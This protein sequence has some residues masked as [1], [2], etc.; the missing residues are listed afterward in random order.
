MKL[1]T[2]KKIGFDSNMVLDGV[3]AKISADDMHKLW[4]ILQDPY[5]NSIGAVVR[6]YVSNS[7]D[8]HA[9]AKFIKENSLTDIRTEYLIYND[10]SDEELL[11]LKKQLEVFDDDAVVV[12]I[13]DDEGGKYWATEDFGV[14]LS[15]SRVVD[16]FA[17]YLKST[18]EN[19]NNVIGAFGIGS[20]S[21]LSYS[22]I[23]FIRTRYNGYEYEYWLRKGEKGPRLD[24]VSKEPTTERNGTRIKIYIKEV[25]GEYHWQQPYIEHNRFSDECIKQLAYFDNVFFNGMTINNH[26]KIYQGNNWLYNDSVKN[27]SGQLHI[28]L[29]KVAYPLDFNTLGIPVI[30]VPLALKFEIGE[31]DIIQTREDIK[32]TPRSKKA[33]LDKIE[34][35]REEFTTKWETENTLETEDFILFLDNLGVNPTM[36][37]GNLA[38]DLT[39]L[40]DKKKLPSYKFAPFEKIGFTVRDTLAGFAFFD[41][42]IE[43]RMTPQRLVPD[44]IG[45]TEG[46]FLK[47]IRGYSCYRISGN[48]D[49]KKNKYIVNYLENGNSCFLVRKKGKYS[50]TLKNYIKYLRLDEFPKSEWRTIISTYQKA[51]QKALIDNT[52]SYDKT[53]VDKDWLASLKKSRTS[54][55]RTQINAEVQ[56]IVNNYYGAYSYGVNKEK[57]RK[58]L[59]ANSK[60]QYVIAPQ[61][62]RETL[63]I[64][65][66]LYKNSFMFRG[67]LS[68][69]VTFATVAPTNVK[70]FEGMDNVKTLDDFLK[71]NTLVFK[72]NM[73]V[74]LILDK[75]TVFNKNNHN[76]AAW[77]KI[78]PKLHKELHGLIQIADNFRALER[79]RENPIIKSMIKMAAENN[80]YDQDIIE[81]AETIEKVFKNLNLLEYFRHAN[82][83]DLAEYIYLAMRAGKVK[84]KMNPHL[85]INLNAKYNGLS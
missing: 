73:A 35:L 52:K 7:F 25:P 43:Y 2:S 69:I 51:A 60:K 4:D 33:I 41:Y 49:S 18:K 40:I 13:Y 50:I 3:D 47:L 84:V 45:G 81:K 24:F 59:I 58:D 29:G 76:T 68:N 78:S 48:T 30:Q 53:V 23:V 21:G 79:Y 10:I 20:K 74:Y 36:M 15:E 14:G 63:R 1:E 19:S 26:Y 6:E 39:K 70:H 17:N 27:F 75:L 37:I 83:E 32:Y 46:M 28:C 54:V 62:K 57:W 22:D 8:S 82:A 38:L 65:M 55:D 61:E 12:G 67:L 64:V 42:K 9:E 71:G 77:A 72:Q 56:E 85:F 16:V 31:L 11:L 66:G 44:N 34:A 5:K 80:L